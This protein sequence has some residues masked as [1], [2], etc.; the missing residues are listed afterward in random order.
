M[1]I[2][3]NSLQQLNSLINSKKDI[4]FNINTQ[5]KLIKIKQ[6]LEEEIQIYNEQLA[7]LVTYCEKDSE[8]NLIQNKDGGVQIKEDMI[9]K[10]ATLVEEI[11]SLKI[12]L[13]DIYFSLDEL[14]DLKLT[15]S[16]LELLDP[17]IK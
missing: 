3:R 16:E 8:G 15:L 2:S 7:S 9:D 5:Y 17:F 4:V 1:I 12:T 11:N 14:Q 6:R 13:P 10:C